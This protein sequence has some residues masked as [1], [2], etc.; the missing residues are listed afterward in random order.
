MQ[1]K[2]EQLGYV[3]SLVVLFALPSIFLLPW[4]ASLL[5]LSPVVTG[6]WIGGNIDTTAAVT[7]AGALAGEEA[8]QIATIVK[9]TQNAL[10][11]VVAVLL[12]LYFS[13]RVPDSGVTERPRAS[14]IWHRFPKFVLGFIATSVIATTYIAAVGDSEITKP[15]ISEINNVRTWAFIFG[16]TSIGLGFSVAAVKR[17][18][19]KP[20][21]AF[22]LATVV[23]IVLALALASLLF[24][25]IFAG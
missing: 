11:G 7:A 25:W 17:A 20:V 8:L 16:F 5:G 2:R 10:I 13:V 6:A 24:G 15:V 18:G 4:L 19:A 12:T 22:A 14:D 1:A 3:A 23:N 21:I 9:T